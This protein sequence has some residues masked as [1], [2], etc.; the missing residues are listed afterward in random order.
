M[1]DFNEAQRAYIDRNDIIVRVAKMID[2]SAFSEWQ[3]LT[4][5]GR[6]VTREPNVRQRYMQARAIALAGEILKLAA[7]EPHLAKQLADCEA[8]QWELL[9]VPVG[10][11][12]ELRDIVNAKYSR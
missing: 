2:V 12:K 9:G 1:T 11:H 10:Q 6:I 3:Y 7:K 5:D 8:A 4:D